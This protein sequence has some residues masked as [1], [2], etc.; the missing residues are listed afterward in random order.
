MATVQM[1]DHTNP[2]GPPREPV[3]QQNTSYVLLQKV[4]KVPITVTS[5]KITVQDSQ[6]RNL[7]ISTDNTMIRLLIREPVSRCGTIIY[8]T[9]YKKL[10]VTAIHD[11]RS[12]PENLPPHELSVWTYSDMQDNFMMGKL[13][14]FIQ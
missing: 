14:K 3:S 5:C 8:R 12:F 4:D 9:N 10:F 2:C 1:S 11:A 6:G 7:Y 13:T